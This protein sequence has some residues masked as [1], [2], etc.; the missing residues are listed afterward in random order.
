M[1]GELKSQ[2]YDICQNDSVI[3]ENYYTVEQLF[4]FLDYDITGQDV[5]VNHELANKDTKVYE[6]FMV[7]TAA[8]EDR[9]NIRTAEDA[10]KAA[11]KL[12]KD[13][14][15]NLPEDDGTYEE[16]KKEKAE[17]VSAA[18]E[19]MVSKARHASALFRQENA[20]GLAGKP[21]GEADNDSNPD[22]AGTGQDKALNAANQ[23]VHD[24]MIV[25]NNLI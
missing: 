1:N 10:M 23:E 15:E 3:M 7:S 11:K 18:M 22:K 21:N 19:E 16:I 13:N 25:V 8:I 5:Y 6:N 14:F 24:V 2:F 4:E 9:P 12:A 20:G 17:S